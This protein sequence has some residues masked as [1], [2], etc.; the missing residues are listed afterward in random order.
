MIGRL[1]PQSTS[2]V[3]GYKEA[4]AVAATLRARI[5]I[6]NLNVFVNRDLPH[7]GHL[8]VELS[9]P[10]LSD[11]PFVANDGVFEL[12]RPRELPAPEGGNGYWMVYDA[13]VTD[14]ERVYMMTGRK[15]LHPR[16]LWRAWR[17]W[18]ETTTLWLTL[19]DVTLGGRVDVDPPDLT[20]EIPVVAPLPPW[21]RKIQRQ[22][23]AAHRDFRRPKFIAG[24]VH[25]SLA[26]FIRQLLS[27]RGV[28][29]SRVARLSA[30]ATFMVFFAGSLAKIYV[31]GQGHTDG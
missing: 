8:S 31:F 10:V 19:R 20:V 26:D 13:F 6:H 15:Y 3:K 9:I 5:D 12:F 18:S 17:L 14:G 11:R 7:A 27:T 2:P 1:A 29:K 30:V 4:S 24:T 23:V 25:I 22:E 28:Q 21:L 16:R